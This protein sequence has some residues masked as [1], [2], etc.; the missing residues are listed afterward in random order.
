MSLSIE[1]A[2]SGRLTSQV[3]ADALLLRTLLQLDRQHPWIPMLVTRLQ[4]AR[5]SGSWGSTLENAAAI[6]ALAEYQLQQSAPADY[7]GVVNL[8]MESPASFSSSAPLTVK[9]MADAP[10]AINAG[11]K[12]EFC[13]CVTRR[14]LLRQPARDADTGLEVRRHWTDRKG[15][16]INPNKLHVGDLVLVETT[17]SAPHLDEND[18]VANV[19]VVDA[20][21][22][23]FE[24]ENPRLI[25]SDASGTD[26]GQADRTEFRDDR[27]VIF[28]SAQRK[29]QK[30]RYAIRAVASGEFA[31]P[32]IEASCMYDAG[33]SSRHHGER[34]AIAR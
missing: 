8:G 11:G 34:V 4:K 21:P 25:T 15:N 7:Q 9:S 29:P 13:I 30:F 18:A 28:A 32:D 2:H 14:G 16:P 23:G 27:V 19:A 10:V 24:V 5:H 31:G 26:V 22:G 3:H 12:G 1:T 17:L 6:T 20:L 33:Y